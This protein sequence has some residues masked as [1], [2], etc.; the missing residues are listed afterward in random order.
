LV[1]PEE[2][3][4][5]TP[6]PAPSSPISRF[7]EVNSYHA[8]L[9]DRQREVLQALLDD[10]DQEALDEI[11][12]ATEANGRA[13]LWAIHSARGELGLEY[14]SCTRSLLELSDHTATV[15]A[16]YAHFVRKALQSQERRDWD[17]AQQTIRNADFYRQQLAPITLASRAC[18]ETGAPPPTNAP[19]P[20]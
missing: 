11:L 19:L 5:G 17:D 1:L 18:L 13:W 12:T 4:G 3:F 7:E 8:D 10:P 20:H 2:S 15:I 14:R 16:N 6:S 9:W